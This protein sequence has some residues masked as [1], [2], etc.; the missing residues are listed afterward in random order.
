MEIKCELFL[1]WGVI[2]KPRHLNLRY[3]FRHPQQWPARWSFNQDSSLENGSTLLERYNTQPTTASRAGI[4]AT[5]LV[6]SGTGV[7]I[8][9]CIT[10]IWDYVY[11]Q[12]VN[13]VTRIW[14]VPYHVRLSLCVNPSGAQTGNTRKH[15]VNTIAADVL[16]PCVA[17]P[18]AATALLM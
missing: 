12:Q 15:E 4:V 17:I 13:A 2:S 1:S 18:S 6:K 8:S 5:G 10:V 14:I 11:W 9:C 7:W 3:T 16:S